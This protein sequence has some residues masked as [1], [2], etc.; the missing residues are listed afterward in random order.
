M[1]ILVL[2][3]GQMIKSLILQGYYHDGKDFDG[4]VVNLLNQK[5]EVA[6][7]NVYRVRSL[8]GVSQ[9]RQHC[10]FFFISD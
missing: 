3:R 6:D 2:C 9:S 8:K 7:A 1:V 5:V 10:L 4:N